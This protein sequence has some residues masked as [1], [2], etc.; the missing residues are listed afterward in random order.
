M[1]RLKKE[2]ATYWLIRQIVG[3]DPRVSTERAIEYMKKLL[4]IY[5]NEEDVNDEMSK[6][7]QERTITKHGLLKIIQHLQATDESQ[8]RTWT[9]G[10]KSPRKLAEYFESVLSYVHVSQTSTDDDTISL[11]N[12]D[13]IKGIGTWCKFSILH[14]ILNVPVYVPG[15]SRVY[16]NGLKSKSLR[17]LL[18]S[19]NTM[20][21]FD[22]MLCERFG[23]VNSVSC[24]C[25]KGTK[26][27]RGRWCVE[28]TK[29]TPE[30]HI[31]YEQFNQK[32]ITEDSAEIAWQCA[33]A[34]SKRHKPNV[35]I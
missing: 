8:K 19:D 11:K 35:V 4:R 28:C 31:L 18:G 1:Y 29:L 32:N 25:I 21:D 16:K 5:Q 26:R 24:K 13:E 33:M 12:C 22:C 23:V 27:K 20:N 34:S 10:R 15:D 2:N 9:I 14:H 30:L 7:R 3:A 17:E 6:P